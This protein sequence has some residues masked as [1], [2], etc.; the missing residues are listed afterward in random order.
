MARARRSFGDVFAKYKTYDDSAGRGSAREWRG[1]FND[2]MGFEEAES[3]FADEARAGRKRGPYAILGVSESD[4]WA[5]VRSAYRR[6]MRENAADLVE[7]RLQA[8]RVAEELPMFSAAELVP[9]L[10]A[11][12]ARLKE[13]NA[14]FTIVERDYERAGRKN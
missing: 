7:G 9:M 5:T 11:A 6:L 1:A 10:A 4:L 13:V 3:Y 2:R 8:G 14:A 12:T